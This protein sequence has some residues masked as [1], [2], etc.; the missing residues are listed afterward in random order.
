MRLQ[1]SS[2]P[3][4]HVAHCTG[5]AD[6]F[7][8]TNHIV[9]QQRPT[10]TQTRLLAVRRSVQVRAESA[11]TGAAGAEAEGQE[12]TETPVLHLRRM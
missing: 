11:P 4:E 2:K 3:T 5:D 10:N 6:V 7:K 1:P 8:R 12:A 9:F